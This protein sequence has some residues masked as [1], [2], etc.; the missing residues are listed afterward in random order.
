MQ[1]ALWVTV[2]V[3]FDDGIRKYRRL[4]IVKLNVHKMVLNAV[5]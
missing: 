3:W 4:I 5:Y 1:V 2:T